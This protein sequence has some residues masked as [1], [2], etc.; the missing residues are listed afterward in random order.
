M[1]GGRYVF[2]G[3][4][5]IMWDCEHC[6]KQFMHSQRESNKMYELHM[7]YKHPEIKY[8]PREHVHACLIASDSL[9]IIDDLKFTKK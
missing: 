1:G 8:I 3:K 2:R 4:C 5:K 7:K 6:D 9:S